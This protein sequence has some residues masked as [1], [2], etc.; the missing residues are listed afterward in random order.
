MKN[1][2]KN[3]A[4]HLELVTHRV[5]SPQVRGRTIPEMEEPFTLKYQFL[6]FLYS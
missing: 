5:L 2:R 3:D 1:S 4:T 6:V